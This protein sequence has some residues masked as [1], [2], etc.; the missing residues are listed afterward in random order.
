MTNDRQASGV[1][2][3]LAGELV[4]S[5]LGF[6]FHAKGRSM[7]PTIQDG[8]ILHIHPVNPRELKIG[9]I[10]LFRDETGFKAHRILH[11]QE[12]NFV[13]RGDASCETDGVV[14]AEQIIGKVIA[15]ECLRTGSIVRLDSPLACIRFFLLEVR[16]QRFSLRSLRILRVLCGEKLFR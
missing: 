9:H 4:A 15:K 16:I 2:R 8:E 1:F 13:T 14:R 6:R 7:L 11:K 10:V 12:R 5:G 3:Q